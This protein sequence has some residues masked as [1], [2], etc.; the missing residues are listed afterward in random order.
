M[1]KIGIESAEVLVIFSC[2][3]LLFACLSRV[4]FF[5]FDELYD[6]QENYAAFNFENFSKAFYTMIV[7]VSTTNYP[8]ALVKA[9]A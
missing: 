1:Y 3:L 7:A 9:Y 6:T 8:M 4:I 5:D 2:A